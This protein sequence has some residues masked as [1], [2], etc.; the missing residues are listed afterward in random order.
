M[1]LPPNHKYYEADQIAYK[2]D[3]DKLKITLGAKDIKLWVD[4]DVNELLDLLTELKKKWL[5]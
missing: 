3:G 5:L 4:Y 2:K 1:I